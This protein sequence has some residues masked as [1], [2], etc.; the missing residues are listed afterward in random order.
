L[1]RVKDIRNLP[2][3]L[4]GNKCDLEETREVSID[5]GEQ[6]A[7]AISAKFLETSA[8]TGTNVDKAFYEIVKEIILFR[9]TGGEEKSGD[10]ADKR[11]KGSKDGKDCRII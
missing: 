8:L 2:F 9:T 10:K 11:G 6:A 5:R 4:I 1:R 7:K 3:I